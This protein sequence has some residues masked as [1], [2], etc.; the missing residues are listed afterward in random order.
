MAPVRAVSKPAP[1]TDGAQSTS[2]GAFRLV[3]QRNQRQGKQQ[4]AQQNRRRQ[5]DQSLEEQIQRQQY[6][7]EFAQTLVGTDNPD[8]GELF[9]TGD[10][11]NFAGNEEQRKNRREQAQQGR[12]S[13]REQRQR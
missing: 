8:D 7:T 13:N 10:A 9:E 3:Q 4:Q 1:A 5:D 6:D 2:G 11:A 12:Q